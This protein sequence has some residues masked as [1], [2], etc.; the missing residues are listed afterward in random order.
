MKRYYVILIIFLFTPLFSAYAQSDCSNALSVCTEANTGGRVNGFGI[1]DFN[2]SEQSGCLKNGLGVT[3]V[4]TNS[5]WFRV[6]L[7]EDGEFGFDITPNDLNEDWDFAVYG[8]NPTCG[9]LGNPIACNYR[10]VSGYTGVGIDPITGIQTSAYDSW[11]DVK[12]GEEYLVLINQY[13]GNNGGFSIKWTGAVIDDN[14]EPLD[15]SIL[16]DLGPDRNFCVGDPGTVLNAT[17]FGGSFSYQW[18]VE[19]QSTGNFDPLPSETAPTLFVTNNGNY[20]VEVTDTTGVEPLKTDE[21]VVTFYPVPIANPVDDLPPACDSDNNGVEEFDLESQTL[22]IVN[23]Q[24]NA[25]VTYYKNETFA[26]AGEPSIPSGTASAYS[27]GNAII[28]ARIESTGNT[29]CY[30]LTSFELIVTPLLNLG[31]PEDLMVCDDNND[32]YYIFNL[33]A[34][35][36][37]ILNNGPGVVKYYEDENNA[38]DD[39]GWIEET[40]LSNYNSVTR[41]IWYRAEPVLDSDCASI[42]SFEI[43]VFDSA[44]ANVPPDLQLCDDNN[45]GFYE[46]D[47][48]AM[49]DAEILGTQ[50]P[51]VF[52]VN[53]FGSQADADNNE[54]RLPNPYFN[55]TPYGQETIYARIEN[56]GYSTCFDT[57]S[58]KVQVFDSA[59][60]PANI[61]DLTYCDDM[62]DGNDTNGF[63][64]FD[65][66]ERE[67]DI[68]AGQ[69]PI[70]FDVTYFENPDYSPASQISNP[71]AF[72]NNVMGGQTIYVRVMNSNP[73]NK[74]C[75]SDTSFNIEVRPLPNA[76]LTVFD[77]QQCDEDGLADG[78]T[79]FN[80]AEAD[81]FLNLGVST[82]NVSYHLTPIDAGLGSNAQVKYPFSNSTSSTLF[83]RVESANGCYRI[84]QVNLSVAVSSIPTYSRELI[85]C[86]DDSTID[87][88]HV[89]DL[90][91]TRSEILALLLP[92][93]N[94]RVAY[95]RS[96]DDALS[97]TNNIIPEN[98]YI[99]EVPFSQT[100]W[101]RVESSIDG[102]CFGISPAIQLTVNPRPE[103]EL[104]ET[105]FVCLNNTPLSVSTFNANDIYTYEWFDELG[106]PFS[107]GPT[108]EIFTG[109]VY[110]VIATSIS[111]CE[112]FPKEITITE[113]N[114]AEITPDDVIISDNSDNNSI[115]IITEN[116]NLGIG[117]YEFA[118]DSGTGPFQDDPTFNQ[119]SPGE[120]TIFVQEKNSCGIVQTTVFVFGFPNFFTPNDDG[121]NDTWNVRGVDP[122]L[123]PESSIYIYDRY[124]KMLVNFT[125]NNVGWD[126]Y[127]NDFKAVSSDY[128]YLAKITDSNGTSREFKG[129]FS[130]IRR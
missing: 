55:V 32:G 103:F 7:A 23:F 85:Q 75:Y 48:N 6:K 121:E 100:I 102:G 8:P 9:A 129:H 50:N 113:S 68:L 88:I 69:S 95:Y 29:E 118:L 60:P 47:F 61:A 82:L 2:G 98:A 93:Q 12:A 112:S 44:L 10:G 54:N 35:T 36:P 127:Y 70:V 39:K 65:L 43:E 110:T 115:T 122:S 67:I 34:Q 53:Y 51:G 78:I 76:L 24:P 42:N 74:F 87:G 16:V 111:G 81:A 25:K 109:G 90:S 4:E 92:N 79:D 18:F 11:M 128:W 59:F 114:I 21:I 106:N 124:G 73:N 15:C 89:F 91:Q 96:Q 17:T 46:F 27:S 84:V 71:Q 57:T 80:L 20:K 63:Y 105:A 86:D 1:D 64:Q 31:E 38:I 62:S 72:T 108:T 119:V 14:T 77:F 126:G 22:D 125:A 30:D 37:V 45:D 28:W 66:R 5:F 19:N 123:F 13:D 120:H 99:N 101:I 3:T 41:T 26:K 52:S 116:Q 33:E 56:V 130:L 117:D 97:E 94:L 40:D 58:F 49:K 107:Q 104:D 83:G